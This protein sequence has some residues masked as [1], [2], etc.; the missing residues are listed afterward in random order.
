MQPVPVDLI[1]HELAGTLISD[2]QP[3]ESLR[4]LGHTIRT[5]VDLRALPA[6]WCNGAGVGQQMSWLTRRLVDGDIHPHVAAETRAMEVAI[7]RRLADTALSLLVTQDDGDR[8]AALTLLEAA[9]RVVGLPSAEAH[10]EDTASWQS[11][12]LALEGQLKAAVDLAAAHFEDVKTARDEADALRTKLRQEE[13]KVLDLEADVERLAESD[14]RADL[15]RDH[16]QEVRAAL[17]ILTNASHYDTIK[18]IADIRNVDSSRPVTERLTWIACFNNGNGGA[19]ITLDGRTVL[20]TGKMAD[21][22]AEALHPRRQNV[23]DLKDKV[24]TLE[25]DHAALGKVE[26]ATSQRAEGYHQRILATNEAL[27]IACNASQELTLKTIGELRQNS[28]SEIEALKST[29]D[30]LLHDL[31]NAK[32]NLAARNTII[33]NFTDQWETWARNLLGVDDGTAQELQALIGKKLS[34]HELR[35]SLNIGLH[36]ETEAWSAWAERTSGRHN[37]TAPHARQVIE[38]RIGD[39]AAVR[40][41]LNLDREASHEDIIETI[42]SLQADRAKLCALVCG[43]NDKTVDAPVDAPRF[44]IGDRVLASPSSKYAKI[45]DEHRGLFLVDSDGSATWLHPDNM[46]QLPKVDP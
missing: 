31:D 19:S 4:T 16:M 41:A 9:H 5:C 21:D 6:Q 37:P 36:K 24:A 14:K 12:V 20:V 11:R 32:A 43:D 18:R 30:K 33:K 38:R 2:L 25:R 3:D 15:Y 17:N 22:L 26:T 34:Q 35:A 27:G 7:S 42:K 8:T 10:A 23:A 40:D 29:R 44:K 28:Y 46:R 39:M 13:A 45:I 1:L